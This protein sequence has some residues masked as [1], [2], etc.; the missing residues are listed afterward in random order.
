MIALS[1]PNSRRGYGPEKCR[2]GRIREGRI[3]E[4]RLSEGRLREGRLCEGRLR[5]CWGIVSMEERAIGSRW[6]MVHKGKS[7]IP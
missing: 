4:G 2:E 5:E 6:F 7:K 3:R 1:D